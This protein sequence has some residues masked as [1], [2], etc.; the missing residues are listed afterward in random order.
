MAG[1]I[2]QLHGGFRRSRRPVQEMVVSIFVFSSGFI[3]LN[4]VLKAMSEPSSVFALANLI[5]LGTVV[6]SVTVIGPEVDKFFLTV[7]LRVYGKMI[8]NGLLSQDWVAED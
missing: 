2:G 6:I 1:D 5:C 8:H 4:L 7:T 3:L